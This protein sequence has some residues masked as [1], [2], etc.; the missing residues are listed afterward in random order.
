M[1]TLSIRGQQPANRVRENV[2]KSKKQFQK[3]EKREVENE[4]ESRISNIEITKTTTQ[5]GKKQIKETA[6]TQYTESA[7]TSNMAG[8]RASGGLPLE[9]KHGG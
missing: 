2:E 1:K 5:R 6:D 9:V 4:E 7:V 8:E 3:T